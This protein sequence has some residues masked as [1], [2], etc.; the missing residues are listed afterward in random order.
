MARV[1]WSGS[2]SSEPSGMM[3]ALLISASHGP[4]WPTSVRNSRQEAGSVTSSRAA[5]TR[6][7]K[8]AATVA[9]RPASRSPIATDAPSRARRSA[10]ARPMPRAPPVTSTAI[11]EILRFI[12]TSGSH[13]VT[14]GLAVDLSDAGQ[15]NRIQHR[16]RTWIFVFRHPGLGELDEFRAAHPL[17]RRELDDGDHLFAVLRVRPPHA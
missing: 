13:P 8:G 6:S 5:A 4:R 12:A 15:R 11:P 7:P 10:V 9:A 1:S 17:T 3:P 16:D 2:F 14:Y